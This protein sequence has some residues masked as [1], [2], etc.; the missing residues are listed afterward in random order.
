VIFG[1]STAGLSSSGLILSESGQSLAGAGVA[2]FG[3]LTVQLG[4]YELF[5]SLISG[6]ATIPFCKL[7]LQWSDSTTGQ[8]T[9]NAN[10]YLSGGKTAPAAIKG[11][12]P[13]QGDTLNFTVTNLDASTTAT[14]TLVFT[15]NARA[16]IRDDWRQVGAM[17][18]TNGYTLPLNEP[19]A[20]LIFSINSTIGGG[21]NATRL[22]PLYNGSIS[23]FLAAAANDT[24]LLSLQYPAGTI[25][26]GVTT[27]TEIPC[28]T[29]AQ[30]PFQAALGN[31]NMLVVLA[32]TGGDSGTFQAA[33]QVQEFQP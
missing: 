26:S 28:A 31:G 11:T 7:N 24:A 16:Y 6:S 14:F 29:A 2:A 33:A 15:Q 8:L 5:F 21:S 32:N 25:Q 20:G 13:S 22:C 19:L 1:S 23:G 27:I 30:T 3:P 4:G 9:G 10:W 12:G 18:V 17:P